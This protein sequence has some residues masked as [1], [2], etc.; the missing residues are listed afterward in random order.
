MISLCATIIHLAKLDELRASYRTRTT[1]F[2]RRVKSL[3]VQNV[4][5][6]CFLQCD[7]LGIINRSR[8]FNAVSREKSS[9]LQRIAC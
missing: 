7:V 8:I 9:R 3:E 5:Y 1:Q 2:W 4:S 6:F